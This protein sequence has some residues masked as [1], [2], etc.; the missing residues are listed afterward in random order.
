ML[1]ADPEKRYT[2]DRVFSHPWMQL[3]DLK[4]CDLKVMMRL[5]SGA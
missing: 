1:D 3:P 5:K 4:E 2:F